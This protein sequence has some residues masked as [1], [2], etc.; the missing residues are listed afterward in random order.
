MGKESYDAKKI[1]ILKGLEA[2]RRRPAMY[3]GDVSS[4]GLHHLLYEVVDNSIDEALGGYCDRIEVILYGD[5]RVSVEDNGRGIPVDTH[6]TQKKPGVEVVLTMLHAG[7]K[8]DDKIYKISGGLHGVG[9]SVVNALSKSLEIEIY[10]EG[11]VYYQQYE[12]G[13][14][15]TPLTVKGKT[16]KRGTFIRFKPDPTIFRTVTFIFDAVLDRM[17]ELAFLNRGLMIVVQD[18]NNNRTET[19]KYD[20][21]LAEFVQ[22]LDEGRTPFHQ[23]ICITASRQGIQIDA[24]FQYTAGFLESIHTFCN[25]INTHEG[26]T[27]LSGFKSALTRM[28]NDYAKKKNLLKGDLAIQGEDTREG[29]TSVLSI[30]M[31]EPQFEGQTK[32]KL[33]NSEVKGVV[34]SVISEKLAAYLEENPKVANII[35]AKVI[36][37]ARAREAAKKARELT[38]RKSLLESDTLPGKL[39]DCSSEDPSV[40]ELYLVEGPSAGGSA[41]QGR[42]RTFQAILPLR[43]KILNVERSRLNRILSNEELRAIITAVGAGIGE[44]E[45]DPEKVRYRK[46]IIMSDAD[47]DGAHIRTLLLTF[48]YRHMRLLVESGYVYIAQPPLYRV[49]KAK[50]EWYLYSDEELE[51]LLKKIGEEKVDI[52]RYKGLGEMNPEQL[53]KT[54]MNPESRIVK[55]VNLED[56]IEADRIFT[57]L[58]GGNT[59][60][61]RRFIEQNA[62][63]VRN[64]DI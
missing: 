28:L 21:G 1:H 44:D 49:K 18:K 27:H 57:A 7:A 11:K 35:M 30:K 25:T 60:L 15:K 63:G 20:G 16:K 41:K 45:F 40:C 62:H 34:D 23:P 2:V 24:A 13:V 22:F 12:R 39:A 31:R 4:R 33:G 14:P 42:D 43:G 3:V 55:R 9:V 17:R 64:L 54:T 50:E 52:Q 38:R 37:A 58:M 10:M 8:F 19:L 47:V 46:V 36:A 56:A 26:G 6:P 5:G 32:T 61:R 48:F 53:W 51:R 29:L 59:E